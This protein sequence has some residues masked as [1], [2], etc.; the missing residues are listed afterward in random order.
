MAKQYKFRP[1]P[2]VHRDRT[3]YVKPRIIGSGYRLV[4]LTSFKRYP[5]EDV[6]KPLADMSGHGLKQL[7]DSPNIVTAK[8]AAKELHA[9]HKR[10]RMDNLTVGQWQR[11]KSL[12]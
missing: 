4:S 5:H 1:M 11:I 9:R 3:K 12:L 6:G 8:Q 7:L 2:T 10:G